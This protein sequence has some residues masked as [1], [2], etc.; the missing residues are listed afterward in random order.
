MKTTTT[1][2]AI[3][4]RDGEGHYDMNGIGDWSLA[5]DVETCAIFGSK[6]EA[7]EVLRDLVDDDG[8]QVVRITRT[9]EVEVEDMS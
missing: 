6:E 4:A 5:G 3:R 8:Y 1:G 7:E 2:F 9:V